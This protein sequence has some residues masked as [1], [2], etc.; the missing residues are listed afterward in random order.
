VPGSE[1][2]AAQRPPQQ[3]RGPRLGSPQLEVCWDRL[4]P[5]PFQGLDHVVE[6]TG[7]CVR[8]TDGTAWCWN[9]WS[10]DGPHTVP[11]RDDALAN[12]VAAI[13]QGTPDR[14]PELNSYF[15]RCLQRFDG[16]LWCRG[17]FN[18]ADNLGVAA[19]GVEHLAGHPAGVG[20]GFKPRIGPAGVPGHGRR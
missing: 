7:D 10:P 5:E 11:W 14:V 12:T 1:N 18:T 2:R 9:D 16:S 4:D 20:S 6:I 3:W 19:G 17:Q 8:K 15:A 13:F